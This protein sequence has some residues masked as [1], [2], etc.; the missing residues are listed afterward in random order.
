MA[1]RK[2]TEIDIPVKDTDKINTEAAKSPAA[3]VSVNTEV[4]KED[5]MNAPEVPEA[6]ETTQTETKDAVKETVKAPEKEDAKAPAKKTA[7]RKTV[8]KAPEKSAEAVEKK[9]IRRVSKKEA[10][11]EIFVQ[12]RGREVSSKDVLENVK[13]IWT[14]E[15]GK[16]DKALKDVKLYIKPEENKVYYVINGDVT[17]AIGL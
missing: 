13:K 16:K 10:A 5:F 14:D 8:K 17:G 4:L 6:K 7:T 1:R 2:I 15:M 9:T 3:E 11:A 12:F